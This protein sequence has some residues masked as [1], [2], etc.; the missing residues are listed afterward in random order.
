M[1]PAFGPLYNITC[2]DTSLIM[3]IQWQCVYGALDLILSLTFNLILGK[4]LR[5]GGQL[6]RLGHHGA[7]GLHGELG[8]VA[9]EA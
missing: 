8:G 6:S 1:G 5:N 4:H 7:H 9:H 2:I 3:L